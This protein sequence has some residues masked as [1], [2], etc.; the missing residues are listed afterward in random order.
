MLPAG[1]GSAFPGSRDLTKIQCRIR[2]TLTGFNS[3]PGSR[4]R[5]NLGIGCGMGKVNDIQD[6]DD[7]RS[8]CGQKCGIG[9][10][11]PDPLLRHFHRLVQKHNFLGDKVDNRTKNVLCSFISTD[12]RSSLRVSDKPRHSR[13]DK[14]NKTSYAL[15]ARKSH[16]NLNTIR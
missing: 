12:L 4:I 10:P 2:E 1:S 3:Y 7:R 16:L 13:S 5:Q 11:F 8:G 6:R 14:G 15:A 9:T